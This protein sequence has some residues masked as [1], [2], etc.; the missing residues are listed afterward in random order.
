MSTFNIFMILGVLVLGI[1][2]GIAYRRWRKR[3]LIS[4][5]RIRGQRGEED[6]EIWLRD[7]G[8]EHLERQNE[9]RF[10]YCVNGSS[11]EFKVRPDL[12]G[13]YR[14]QRWLIEVKTGKSASPSHSATRRQLREYAQLWPRMRY[15][16][17]DATQGV[18][19]EVSFDPQIVHELRSWV[20]RLR[21]PPALFMLTLGLFIGGAVGAL[22]TMILIQS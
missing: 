6:A 4:A 18:L 12:M 1:W 5:N 19:H 9:K 7:F 21:T 8:F 11:H 17:L 14:G 10:A 3:L 2:V 20:S 16:L 15:G 22:L 13:Y